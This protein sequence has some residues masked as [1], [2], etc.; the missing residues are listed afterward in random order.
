MTVDP[1]RIRNFSIIAHIDHGKSTLADRFL[2]ITGAVTG[3]DMVAQFLDQMELER[4]RGITIKGKAV[5][6]TAKGTDGLS[7]QLNLI[8]TP[9]HVDFGYEVSRAL[10]SCEGALLIVDASQGI[11]AQTIANAFLALDNNLTLIPVVNKVDL[12]QAEPERVADDLQRVFGFNPDEII[13]TSAKEGTGVPEVVQA[14]IERVPPPK[15][16]AEG[17]LRGLVFDSIYNPYKGIVAYVRIF[18]GQASLSDRLLIMSSSK[19]TDSME[20]GVF[21]PQPTPTDSLS[22]GQVGYI[23]TGLKD[24][25]E[26]AVGDTLTVERF[27]AKDPLSGYVPLKPMVFAGLYPTDGENYQS[28]R[29]ALEKLQLNDAALSFEAESSPALGFGARCGFLG[30]LHMDIVQER[31]EREYGLDIVVT[32]PSVVYKVHM[33]DGG[34]IDVK[35]PARLP[36]PNDI[37]EVLEPWLALTIVSPA[38][39]VGAVMELMST[40]R[41]DYKRMEYI[42]AASDGD[43]S[44][45]AGDARVLMEYD[46][47]MSEL[48]AEFYNRLKSRTQGYASLDYSFIGYRSGALVKLDIL[49]NQEPVDALSM[50]VHKDKSYQYGRTLVERLKQAIPRQLFEVPIQAAVGNRIIARE[51]VRAL[52][53]DVLAKCYGGDITRKRKL[54]ERQKEGKKRLKKVGSVDVPQEAFLALLKV[55]GE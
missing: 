55:E 15:G 53:K 37:E 9:G 43:D 40:R 45:A 5:T 39:H 22:M 36:S 16:S 38:R 18:D 50:I 13:F 51:T 23:A 32:A 19:T 33:K 8:D 7:Y 6:M 27:P 4:E 35:T 29:D 48:L 31:L 49:L 25:R 1:A 46:M 47:P 10:A 44:S 12:P 21:S 34:A 17:P 54:L 3:Q 28:L 2:E 14:V 20:I 24:V 30:L 42:Q 26:C 11:E 52:R 41:A